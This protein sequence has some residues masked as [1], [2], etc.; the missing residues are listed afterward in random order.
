LKIEI[1][2]SFCILDG[3]YFLGEKYHKVLSRIDLLNPTYSVFV[4]GEEKNPLTLECYLLKDSFRVKRIYGNYLGIEADLLKGELESR[5]GED[6]YLVGSLKMDFSKIEFLQK[7]LKMKKGYE[8][9]GKFYLLNK[10][11]KF[12][13]FKGNLFGKNFEIGG[14]VL[15]TL[16]GKVDASLEELRLSDLKVSD[17]AGIVVVKDIFLKKRDGDWELKIPKIEAFECRP[18]LLKSESPSKKN[19][20][21]LVIRNFKLLDVSGNLKDFST[22]KGHGSFNFLNSFKRG[23]NVFEIPAE[24]LGRILGLDLELLVPVTGEV[25]FEIRDRKFLLS[26]IFR[27]YSENKRSKFFLVDDSYMDFEGNLN[28]NVKMKQYVLFK[29]TEKFI[30]SIKGNIKDPDLNLRKKKF[31]ERKK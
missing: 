21:P 19:I 22:V 14:Y 28:I 16:C 30:L 5:E 7:R 2:N 1:D 18:S 10:F 4:F 13:G 26:K 3:F 25:F 27:V 6:Y 9:K 23:Y 15:K 29:I 12:T 20:K 17:S 8:L 11:P 24:C 31:F